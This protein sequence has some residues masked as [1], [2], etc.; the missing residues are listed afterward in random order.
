MSRH[1]TDEAVDPDYQWTATVSNHRW[2]LL[3]RSRSPQSGDLR[4]HRIVDV[5]CVC[6]ASGENSTGGS[7]GSRGPRRKRSPTHR[8]W[9]DG[10]NSTGGSEMRRYVHRCVALKQRTNTARGVSCD[11]ACN[12]LRRDREK[13]HTRRALA[14]PAWVARALL[15]PR[16]KSGMARC[17]VAWFRALCLRE[18]AVSVAAAFIAFGASIRE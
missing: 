8:E 9:E 15:L 6:N 7:G 4:V 10:E 18:K 16:K 2:N 11:V 1:D 13:K 14:A 17:M 3:P 12:L 5:C